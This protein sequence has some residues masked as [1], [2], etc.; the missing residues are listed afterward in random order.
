MFVKLED[1]ELFNLGQALRI[2]VME[3]PGGDDWWLAA[4]YLIGED[5][6]VAIISSGTESHCNQA[7]N[8]LEASLK[9][10]EGH[11]ASHML[12]PR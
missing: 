9:N 3:P 8:Q 4:E 7:L 6:C 12:F 5:H 1:G 2:K 11:L 10:P